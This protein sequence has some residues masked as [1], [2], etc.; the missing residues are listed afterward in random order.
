MTAVANYDSV[1]N[2]EKIIETAIANFGRIDVL[3]NNAG[4]LRDIT[5]K[6]MK[7][8][9]WDSVINVHLQ[10]AYKCTKAAWPHFKRQKYGRIINT[11]SAAG[12][13]GSFGQCNYSAAKLALVGFTQTIAKEGVKY[14]VLSNAIAPIAASR[15][16]ETI[17]APEM[18]AN[19][20]PGW[21]V[22]LVAVLVHSSS[23]ETG[24]I[25]EVGGGHIAKLRWERAKGLVLKPD[26]TYTPGAILQEWSKISDF[27]EPEHP[28]GI[29]DMMEKLKEA[30]TLDSND[31]SVETLDFTGRVALVT[32][33][34]A[35]YVLK[36]SSTL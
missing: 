21:V 12:L 35:G 33:G 15:M 5:F 26:D 31:T 1:E 2:G 7:D 17:W 16:T 4:I 28:N 19:I 24:S 18:L 32:G 25:F 34:G 11:T 14:N 13:F 20:A 6:N 23:S 29:A 30:M 36:D 22:P 27:S 3:V 10:G 9:D 8:Q